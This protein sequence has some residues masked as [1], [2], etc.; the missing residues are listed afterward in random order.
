MSLR[1]YLQLVRDG[2]WWIAAG[3]LFGMFTGLLIA[4]TSVPSYVATS[5]L[6]F[7]GIEGGGEPGQVYQGALLAEQKARAYADLIVSDRVL[8]EVANDTTGACKPG[9]G[10]VAAS[11]IT[12]QSNAGNPTLVLNVADPSP[13]RAAKIA[14]TLALKAADLVSDLER[15]NDPRLSTVTAVRVLA[16]ADVPT[17]PTSPNLKVNVLVGAVVGT[18]LGL[19]VALM[20]RSL[21][22]SVRTRE[23]LE[24]LTGL[25]LLGAIPFEKSYRRSRS[26]APARP[27]G[28]VTE[29]VRQLRVNL[30]SAGLGASCTSL[31]VT[32]S[33]AGEGKTSLVCDLATA[34]GL[35]GDRVLLI[36]ADLRGPTVDDYLH[37]DPPA[38]LSTVLNGKCQP[39]SAVES[40][41]G[42]LFDVLASGPMPENPSEL[43]GSFGL[44]L[45]ELESRYDVVLIDSPALL[46]VADARVLARACDAA[47]LVVRQGHTPAS[48]ITD[49]LAALRAVSARVLG[50]AL[51]RVPQPKHT[52]RNRVPKY[53]GTAHQRLRGDHAGGRDS[54][55]DHAPNLTQHDDE[56]QHI[57]PPSEHLVD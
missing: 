53:K 8:N 35:E 26:I 40:F 33:L 13:E 37:L 2:R 46:P 23:V 7:S 47:L 28:H 32:S 54:A 19:L 17:T 31:L 25:P 1:E 41:R 38:G 29:A 21:D 57:G 30:R 18:A 11:A 22:R 44:M 16:P 14:D 9:C 27:P 43:L 45:T 5:T 4:L 39:Q 20:R 10:P 51:T 52:S 42:G 36:D 48:E 3:L 55:G 12:I 34:F 50:C 49:A 15:P 56:Q 24:E 6:Y